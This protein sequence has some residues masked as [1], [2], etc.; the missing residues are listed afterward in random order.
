MSAQRTFLTVGGGL[1]GLATACRLHA[2]DAPRPAATASLASCQFKEP[3]RSV[4]KYSFNKPLERNNAL[5]LKND[6]LMME[7]RAAIKMRIVKY[8]QCLEPWKR[9]SCYDWVRGLNAGFSLVGS[10]GFFKFSLVVNIY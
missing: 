1:V 3:G 7:V 9:K 8:R 4:M 10:L 6:K 2:F 5:P